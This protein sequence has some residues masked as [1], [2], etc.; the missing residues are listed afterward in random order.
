M[1]LLLFLALVTAKNITENIAVNST[2]VYPVMLPP[3]SVVVTSQPPIEK[4]GPKMKCNVTK[5]CFEV[6]PAA[7]GA[8]VKGI[9]NTSVASAVF[10]GEYNT[11]GYGVA[12]ISQNSTKKEP[13]YSK[14]VHGSS[15]L[16][17]PN[18]T[19]IVE[20]YQFNRKAGKIEAFDNMT[21]VK[22]VDSQ[23]VLGLYSPLLLPPKQQ[24]YSIVVIHIPR[25]TKNY[26][27]TYKLPD[28][29]NRTYLFRRQS[30]AATFVTGSE[31]IY[32]EKAD[33]T[34]AA[35]ITTSGVGQMVQLSMLL[36]PF[37]LLAH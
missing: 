6:I 9:L 28:K 31:L 16:N 8:Y 7:M 35:P 2:V 24:N 27:L 11:R 17:V 10:T 25:D 37:I 4:A 29:T 36:M 14:K 23:P 34:T 5:F 33:I 30:I 18:G 20:I 12:Y 32:F 22:D 26:T 21:A 19:R 1:L 15:K 3:G 13:S